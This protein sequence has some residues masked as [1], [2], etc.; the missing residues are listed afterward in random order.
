LRGRGEIPRTEILSKFEHAIHTGVDTYQCFEYLGKI[1]RAPLP[2]HAR[3]ELKA[4]GY[5][6]YVRDPFFTENKSDMVATPTTRAHIDKSVRKMD[7]PPVYDFRARTEYHLAHKFVGSMYD[8]AFRAPHMSTDEVFASMD[9]TKSPGV[10]E[11]YYGFRSKKEYLDRCGVYHLFDVALTMERVYWGVSGKF[12]KVLRSRYVEELKQRTFIIEGICPLFHRKRLYGGQN[13]RLKL[14]G[15]SSYGL[16]PYNGGTNELGS[17][18]SKFRRFVFGDGKNWDRVFSGMADVYELRN[19]Y[20]EFDPFRQWVT[21]CLIESILVTPDGDIILKGWSNNSGS[22]TTTGDNIIWMSHVIATIFLYLSKGDLSVFDHVEVRVFGDDFICADNLPFS[23]EEVE[24][25]FQTVATWFGISW[26]PLVVQHELEGVEFLGFQFTNADGAWLPKYNLG[27]LCASVLGT[28]ESIDG[29][30]EINKLFSLMVMSL[31]HGPEVFHHFRELF[32][33]V[34]YNGE[35][36]ETTIAFQKYGVPSFSAVKAFY[37]GFESISPM[38]FNVLTSGTLS[39]SGSILEGAF[40]KLNTTRLPNK[41]LSMTT[42]PATSENRFYKVMRK[43]QISDAGQHWLDV[44]LDPFK[45]VDCG[46]PGGM[47]DEITTPSIVQVIPGSFDVTVPSGISGAWDCNIFFD[48]LWAPVEMFSYPFRTVMDNNDGLFLD[49]NGSSPTG[50]ST[51]G[52]IQVRA[53]AAGTPL[54][55]VTAQAPYEL[56]TDWATNTSGNTQARIIAMG[57]EIHNVTEP[58]LKGGAVTVYRCPQGVDRSQVANVIDSGTPA[59]HDTAY[60]AFQ[61][62]DPPDTVD[63]AIDLPQSRGWDADDGAYIVPA[64]CGAT[65]EPSSLKIVCPFT[66]EEDTSF[67]YAPSALQQSVNAATYNIL[68]PNTQ[69][70]EQEGSAKL[71]WTVSGAFFTDLN[72]LAK[73]H[74]NV[75]LYIEIFPD[76]EN[77]MRRSCTP[78]PGLDARALKLYSEIKGYLPAGVPVQEN[79]IGMFISTIVGIATRLFAA[80]ATVGPSIVSG[81]NAVSAVSKGVSTIGQGV[82]AVTGAFNKTKHGKEGNSMEI[83]R[84]DK[85]K[86]NVLAKSHPLEQNHKQLLTALSKISSSLSQLKSNGVNVRNRKPPKHSLPKKEIAATHEVLTRNKRPRTRKRRGAKQ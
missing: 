65:N 3:C 53:A 17:I 2:E 28:A 64:I 21:D 34:L 14:L 25:A 80:A 38:V 31:G 48:Q 32:I 57:M 26:D 40:T 30:G 24:T 70:S 63:E 81:A 78:S 67:L 23:D 1:G 47:P 29:S 35:Q 22:G 13:T 37:L 5:L 85:Q 55:Q 74:V 75:A 43:M 58:L 79:F 33:D 15:W 52:G 61:L 86:N 8:Y 10:V 42:N 11:V 50:G 83:K 27:T 54:T 9:L 72:N 49:L 46:L 45:D 6:P 12:E 60:Q 82:N 56:Q 76:K 77:P 44:V 66:I 51:R 59:A 71:P 36:N 69:G 73:L 16:N 4:P 62:V 20:A 19:G 84:K 7:I 41:N 39:F 18:L 68:N